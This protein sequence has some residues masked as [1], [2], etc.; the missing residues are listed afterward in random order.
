MIMD[1][2]ISIKIAAQGPFDLKRTFESGHSSFPI[3]LKDKQDRWYLVMRPT[4]INTVIITRVAQQGSNLVAEIS[5]PQRELKENEVQSMKKILRTT[6]GLQLNLAAFIEEFKK[7]PIAPA[8]ELYRGIR[9]TRAHNLFQSLICSILTQRNSIWR[10][11]AQARTM[12]KLL[13]EKYP[14]GH[15]LIYSFPEAKTI[16]NHSELLTKASLGYREEYV[17]ETAKTL[18]NKEKKLE[19]LKKVP[20]NEAQNALLELKGVGTKVADMFLLYGLGK[21]DAPPVDIWIQRAV[22]HLFFKKKEQTLAVC[23]DKLN[24]HYGK[25]AGLAQLYI[26]CWARDHLK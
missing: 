24:E 21:M 8:F 12:A 5:C 15:F 16:V 9:L 26:Y 19:K 1:N 2:W 4:S 7:D 23:R 6:F 18:A 14:V 3:P 17:L 25:W 11:N 10:W 20:T 13:G 22:S